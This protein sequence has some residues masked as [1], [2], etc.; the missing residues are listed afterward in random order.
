MGRPKLK[1]TSGTKKI[2]SR[3]LC[4]NRFLEWFTTYEMPKTV[5]IQSSI[6]G[7]IYRL[8]Q[9][10]IVAYF[11][12]W[13]IIKE[14]GYQASERPIYGV[15]AQLRG[16]AFSNVQQCNGR[17]ASGPIVYSD[18][19][20]VRPPI[21]N[22]GFFLITR[23]YSSVE[24]S[25]YTCP[26]VP[27]LL[28]A[29]CRKDSQCP[30][31]RIAGN[32]IP[33]EFAYLTNSSWFDVENYGHGPFTGRCLSRTMTCEVFSWCP[34]L[35]STGPQDYSWY[36]ST[37][38]D[39]DDLIRVNKSGCFPNYFEDRFF[40]NENFITPEPAT[41][42]EDK[43][44]P[45]YEVLNFTV[46]LRNSIEF[47]FYKVKRTNIL[48][49]MN[50]IYLQTCHF[51]ASD[52]VDRHCP[53]FRIE[54]ILSQSG[55]NVWYILRRGGIVDINIDWNCNLDKALEECVP[56]YSFRYLGAI[57][58]TS[59]GEEDIEHMEEKY[60]LEYANY[61]SSIQH[62]RIFHKTNGI[63][64][65]ISVTGKG[66]RF[67]LLEFSMKIGSCLGL[68]GTASLICNLILVHLSRDA[69]RYKKTICHLNT[70]TRNRHFIRRLRH[71]RPPPKPALHKPEKLAA[72]V[73]FYATHGGG[74]IAPGL[75][76]SMKQV[77]ENCVAR[78]F[79][80]ERQCP[81]LI[82]RKFSPITLCMNEHGDRTSSPAIE[83]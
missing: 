57:T 14:Q 53:R 6:V 55:A 63:Q 3:A 22:S 33:A 34:V 38:S 64:F 44:D 27:D 69:E 56:T 82:Q 80:E 70:L 81:S 58:T 76:I 5:L 67:S 75:K 46:L 68:F 71:Y 21:Q 43:V 26:E 1:P 77:G 23:V 62:K 66:G 36:P 16:T 47:P 39:L 48:E 37:P 35:E 40:V 49:W 24:Q 15:S 12:G 60:L 51:N 8:L 59:P 29:R 17:L 9:I 32:L 61:Y 4:C 2:E 52:K 74:I 11:A 7:V 13:V 28:D 25:L 10:F 41:L 19:D 20:L 83:I 31:G 72:V 45:L 79:E 50:D 73:E 42:E 30:K 54:D 65:L 78:I 18:A